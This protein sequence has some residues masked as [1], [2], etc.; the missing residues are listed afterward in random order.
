MAYPT[1]TSYG[2]AVDPGATEAVVNLFTLK[3]RN[4]ASALPLVAASRGQVEA[5]VARL[6][7]RSATLADTFWPGPLSLIV[8][9]PDW[10]VP[11][12]HG[13]EGTVAI[14]VPDHPVAR[15]LAEAFGRPVTATSANR[16]GAAPA[17]TPDALADLA[18]DERVFMLDAGRTPGGAPSTIVDARVEPPACIRLGAVAWERVLT[19]R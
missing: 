2:L 11:E 14:R 3:G 4:R 17:L 5:H 16:S 7:G 12:V 19:S 9:A 8:D 18:S 1:D 13:G 15:A 10:I 6:T